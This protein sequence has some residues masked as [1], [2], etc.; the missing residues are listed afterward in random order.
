MKKLIKKLAL[1]IPLIKKYYQSVKE[2]RK[3]NEELKRQ[4]NNELNNVYPSNSWH[5]KAQ[6]LNY[7]NML[8]DIDDSTNLKNRYCPLCK[9]EFRIFLAGGPVFVRKNS[10]CPNCSSM[11]R[12]RMLG[13]FLEEKTDIF[14][15]N[16]NVKLLHFAPEPVFINKFKT[17]NNNIDYYPVDFNDSLEGIREKV[18]IQSIPYNDEM[19]D[20]IICF[21]VLEH[22]PNDNIAIKELLRCLKRNGIAF[23]AVPIDENNDTTLEN[24]EYNTPELRQK[25]YG[26]DDHVR[27][28][29]KDF[30]KRLEKAGFLVEY[31]EPNKELSNDE[32]KRY[33]LIRVEGFYI[34]TPTP[35]QRIIEYYW[36][37]VCIKERKK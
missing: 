13:K 24:P 29:G 6:L 12:H 16:R 20:F 28:Y 14:S 17:Y 2:L 33:G 27:M 32:I 36:V 26:Q 7:E 21:H 1:N 10:Q 15:E 5:L 35:P 23:I 37:I 4:L 30:P 18:D 34:C 3:D 8:D 19:F 25:Y 9:S 31:I 22:I 11:E